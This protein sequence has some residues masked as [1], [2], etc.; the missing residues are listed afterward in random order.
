M[1]VLCLP[2]TSKV[3]AQITEGTKD[4]ANRVA[5]PAARWT[6]TTLVPIRQPDRARTWQI[7]L[8]CRLIVFCGL[9]ART[10]EVRMKRL[11]LSF[12]LLAVI[13]QIAAAAALPTLLP[14][15]VEQAI[16]ERIADG[17][18]PA[19]V[20]AVVDGD[21]SYVYGFGK[22]SNDK[23]PDSGTV[24]QIGS[25][26]KTF[27]ATLLAEAVDKGEVKLDTL[28]A[29]LLPGF[30]LPSRDGKQIT[31]GEIASQ[32]SGL[33]RMPSNFAPTN[34]QD[35]YADYD[36]A[37]LRASLARAT[38]YRAIPA[39]RMNI[40]TSAS[41]CSAMRSHN[42]PANRMQSCCNLKS[43][44]R[45]ACHRPALHS[46]NRSIHAG[47]LGTMKSASRRSLGISAYWRALARSTAPVRTCCVTWK[48]TWGEAAA[49]CGTQCVSRT[50]Q[51][52]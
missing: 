29:N 39:R 49:P 45:S 26:T 38:R 48:P 19:M 50:S 28:G 18:Y 1:Y 5:T 13:P 25:V 4:Q 10:H 37:K 51:G 44:R 12:V 32:F 9:P 42:T 52:S 15:R 22:L 21:R 33:P 30:K 24:F 16:T 36:A 2:L 7:Q 8:R 17:E 46:D 3:C 14:S 11:V 23:P 20:V 31:L 27:T 43:W 34:P 41:A 35:P 47:P 40:R 6:R